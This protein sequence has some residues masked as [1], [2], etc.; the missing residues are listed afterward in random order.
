MGASHIILS[1]E[2]TLP[3]ARDIGGG[4]IVYGRIPL[5]ITERCFMKDNGGCSRCSN[6][7]LEDRMGEKFPMIREFDHRSLILNSKI[8]YMGDK[9]QLLDKNRIASYHFIFSTEREDKIK[10]ALLSFEQGKPLSSS[11]VRRVGRRK[12]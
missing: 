10:T 3:Q 5:M 9:R 1:P 2:I 12:S 8:T 6:L 4:V 7:S 11:E